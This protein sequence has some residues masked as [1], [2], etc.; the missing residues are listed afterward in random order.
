[1]S[2]RPEHGRGA[3]IGQMLL[4]VTTRYN[5]NKQLTEGTAQQSKQTENGRR[6]ILERKMSSILLWGAREEGTSGNAQF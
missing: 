2:S 5:I 3:L 6:M 4:L 1:M